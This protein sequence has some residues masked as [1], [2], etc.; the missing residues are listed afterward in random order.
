MLGKSCVC[1]SAFFSNSKINRLLNLKERR[2]ECM[3]DGC[4]CIACEVWEGCPIYARCEELEATS[5]EQKKVCSL[6]QPKEDKAKQF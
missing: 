2:F 1:F 3:C 5:C 6:Y 4:L